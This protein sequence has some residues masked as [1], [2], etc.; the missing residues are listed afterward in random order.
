MKKKLFH[1]K[2]ILIVLFASANDFM[3][4]KKESVSE[5]VRKFCGQTYFFDNRFKSF[6]EKKM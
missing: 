3:F 2:F 1:S 4:K 6:K 5:S